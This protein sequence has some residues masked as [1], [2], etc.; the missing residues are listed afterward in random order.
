MKSKKAYRSRLAYLTN[1]HKA[2]HVSRHLD[3]L[4]LSKAFAI[5]ADPRMCPRKHAAG[6]CFVA[7]PKARC[8]DTVAYG[9]A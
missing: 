7:R 6:W 3:A 8:S 5:G 1:N 4:T 9:R 2:R